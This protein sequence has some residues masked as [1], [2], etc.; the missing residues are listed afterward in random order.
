VQKEGSKV[1]KL[2]GKCVAKLLM[3]IQEIWFKGIKGR[4]VNK[5]LMLLMALAK[6]QKSINWA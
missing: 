4:Y 1:S 5:K 2:K 3:L 6:L